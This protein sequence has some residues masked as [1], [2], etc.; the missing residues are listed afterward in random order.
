M[1]IRCEIDLKWISQNLTGEK[2]TLAQV[3]FGV[4]REQANTRTIFYLDQCRHMASL[5]LSIIPTG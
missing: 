1:D 5:I 4:I 2:S 3:M